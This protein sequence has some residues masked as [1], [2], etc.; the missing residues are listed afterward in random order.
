[1][2]QEIIDPTAGR[3]V[4]PTVHTRAAA[5]PTSLRNLRVGLLENTKRNAAEV[6]D[7]IGRA[8]L[9]HDGVATLTAYRKENFALPLPDDF[10]EEIASECDVVVIGVGDCG[11]CSAAAI[12]DGV[13]LETLGL[14]TAV[15][16][17]DAFEVTSD[18]MAKLKGRPDFPYIR[19]AH[20]VANLSDVEVDA[21]AESLVPPVRAVLL[22]R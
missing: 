16:C 18:A 13:A 12:A 22:A 6:L 8:L 14:P 17:T 21:R 15:I 10:I 3:R 9:D 20:P 2:V 19:T 5:R 4:R 1:M 11:S 7:S